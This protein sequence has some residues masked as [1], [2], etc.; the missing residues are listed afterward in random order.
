MEKN[1][2]GRIGICK[3]C[4]Q[5]MIIGELPPLPAGV[6]Y[7]TF[8]EDTLDDMYNDAATK[9]CTCDEGKEWRDKQKANTASDESL[10]ALTEQ[11]EYMKDILAA[12][13]NQ[14]L[15]HPELKG[16]SATVIDPVSS[17]KRAYKLKPDKDGNIIATRNSTIVSAEIVN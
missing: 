16:I 1:K 17:E 4:G 3:F 13:R 11:D 8:D 9:E 10:E 2:T 7:D 14:M 6:T 12:G 5:Q 15:K